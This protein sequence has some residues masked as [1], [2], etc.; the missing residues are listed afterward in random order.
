VWETA[1]EFAH[2][3]V[4]FARI[5]AGMDR[6]RVIIRSKSKSDLDTDAMKYL[7]RDFGHCEIQA[8]ADITEDSDIPSLG[9]SIA[10]A[11][12]AVGLF[13]TS[14]EEA[15]HGGCPVL[16]W[17]GRQRYQHLRARF[18]PP[19]RENRA[20]VYGVRRTEDLRPM[21]ESIL[22]AHEGAPLTDREMQDYCWPQSA[23][24]VSGLARM[25]FEGNDRP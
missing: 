17:G 7:V 10:N 3:I 11:D 9:E 16:L 19:T 15:I 12:L 20:A 24:N 8:S 23:P 5:T 22:D 4:D 1:D 25:L 21:L 18:S 6:C 2:S 14:L 13:S